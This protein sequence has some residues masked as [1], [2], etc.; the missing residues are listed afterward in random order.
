MTASARDRE[1]R[2]SAVSGAVPGVAQGCLTKFAPVLA[3]TGPER[4]HARRGPSMSGRSSRRTCTQ[5]RARPPLTVAR[6][7]VSRAH[8]PGRPV[9]PDRRKCTAA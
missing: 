9:R 8:R 1:H 2:L 5:T 7:A 3:L 4:A 6:S